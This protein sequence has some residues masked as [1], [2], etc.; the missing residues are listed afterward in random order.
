MEK[1]IETAQETFEIPQDMSIDVFAVIVKER[2]SH[3]I[4]QVIE[5]RSLFVTLVFYD[6]KISRNQ[7]VI[8][9][10]KDMLEYYNDWRRAESENL[11]W[12]ED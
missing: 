12:R 2:L 3:K 8:Q 9:N 10:I 7:K 5:N 4:I 1:E 6:K 11:N